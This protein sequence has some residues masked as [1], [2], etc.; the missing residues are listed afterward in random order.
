MVLLYKARSAVIS[1]GSGL[2]AKRVG[3]SCAAAPENGESAVLFSGSLSAKHGKEG[4][5]AGFSTS[6]HAPLS[7]QPTP[8]VYFNVAFYLL[9][10][11]C[12]A[13]PV[14]GLGVLLMEF[15]NPISSGQLTGL[16]WADD[17]GLMAATLHF[18]SA[19]APGITS[20]GNCRR[21]L[22]IHTGIIIN[23]F[24]PPCSGLTKKYT[25]P[26]H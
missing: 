16:F 24:L 7:F 6:L 11:L 14:T 12:A 2:P 13:K 25:V 10:Y 23:E 9:V 26:T 17:R 1:S 8:G 5:S 21:D 3:S 4:P 22:I 18:T 19:A 20:L 15:H